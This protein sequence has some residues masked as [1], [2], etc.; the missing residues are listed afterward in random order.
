MKLSY[1]IGDWCEEK[2]SELK[3]YVHHNVW[4]WK[5]ESVKG[6]E[7]YANEWN[8]VGYRVAWSRMKESALKMVEEEKTKNDCWIGHFEVTMKLNMSWISW[9]NGGLHEN[10]LSK[11]VLICASLGNHYKRTH[12]LTAFGKLVCLV[13]AEKWFRMN[14]VEREI[15]LTYNKETLCERYQTGRCLKFIIVQMCKYVLLL[16]RYMQGE[17]YW[18]RWMQRVIVAWLV[19]LACR[20]PYLRNCYSFCS[21]MWVILLFRNFFDLNSVRKG[22]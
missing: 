21:T 16:K 19:M 4:D 13:G 2:V 9:E 11:C 15:K 6:I 8:F 17:C 10:Y 22:M 14:W 1:V 12:W 7:L 18:I 20:I 3:H 5:G